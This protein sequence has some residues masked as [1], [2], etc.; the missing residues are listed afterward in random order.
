ML[1]L[2]LRLRGITELRM[3]KEGGNNGEREM[4]EERK[5]N[6]GENMG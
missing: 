3:K 4:N 6:N 1:R 2:R 5:S